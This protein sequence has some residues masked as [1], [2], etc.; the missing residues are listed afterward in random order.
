MQVIIIEDEKPAFKKLEK[1]LYEY[2]DDAQILA[3]FV[4]IEDAL[5]KSSLFTEADLILSDIKL[6][7]GSSFELFEQIEIL[8]PI[9]F[10]TTYNKYM[11]DAFE[12]QGIAY[13]I[14]PFSQESFN[15]ALRKF[16]RL[17]RKNQE[18]AVNEDIVATLKKIVG[19]ERPKY[20]ERF[21][22]KKKQGL[23][24]ISLD[25]ILYFQAAGDFCLLA[26]TEG[27]KHSI[28]LMISKL[29]TVLNPSQFF[30]INRSEIVHIEAIE[31]VSF[32]SKNKLLICLPHQIKLFTSGSRTA[33]FKK[34]LQGT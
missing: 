26:D 30:R 27:R 6:L 33:A 5:E 3:W 24:L 19:Q 4:S 17:F 25:Q 32:Y 28:N 15:Q 10:C 34:W 29:E 31:K 1:Y 16:E 12:T 21:I 8:C 18:M 20:K 22:S 2:S 14:K 9:I 13:L 7:D 11:Q 23:I